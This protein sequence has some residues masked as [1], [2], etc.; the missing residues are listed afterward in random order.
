MH[1]W[2]LALGA[3]YDEALIHARALGADAVDFRV[4]PA[5]PY[6]LATAA[7]SLAGLNRHA[8]A[9]DEIERAEHEAR[10]LHD[11]NG[12]QNAYAIRVR[13]LLQA[14]AVPEA[15][16]TEPP[17]LDEAL[18]SMKGEVQGSRA[19]ALASIGRLS[20]ARELAEEAT[21]STQGIE[22]HALYHAVRA[23]CA[24]KSREDDLVEQ[25]EGFLTHVFEAGA[26]DIAVTAYRADSEFLS[27]L[28]ASNHRVIKRSFW[29]GEPAMISG[30]THWASLPRGWSTRLFRYQLAS[31]RCMTL[32]AK[33]C[34]TLKSESD[35]SSRRAL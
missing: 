9:L 15:C 21:G 23:I 1:A 33:D 12:V 6:G 16:A 17:L 3:Y 10:R 19:L 29:S 4:E 28:P 14:G 32:F 7:V 11:V 35:C 31:V 13:V 8:E 20:E 34:L 18:P 5:L 30:W 27:A 22:A 2:A 26:V 25:C 24:L